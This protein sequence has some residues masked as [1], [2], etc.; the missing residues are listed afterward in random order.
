MFTKSHD[1]TAETLLIF[2]ALTSPIRSSDHQLRW[3]LP[4]RKCP[5]ELKLPQQ[6][7]SN[8]FRSRFGATRIARVRSDAFL[9]DMNI[10][11]GAA[12]GRRFEVLAQDLPSFRE[13]SWLWTSRCAV[14]CLQVSPTLTLPLRERQDRERTY[15]ELT[16]TGRCMLVVV[17]VTSPWTDSYPSPKRGRSPST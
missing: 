4:V 7:P 11:V 2:D 10:D 5:E 9:R 13:R 8:S 16:G 3:H 14:S 15:L 1:H 12:D 17:G 6:I